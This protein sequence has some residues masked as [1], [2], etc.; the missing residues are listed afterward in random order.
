MDCGPSC[1]RMIAA[2]Y[3]KRFSI[4]FLQELTGVSR[5]GATMTDLRDAAEKI[6]FRSLPV[7]IPFDVLDKEQPFPAILHW[8]R[9]HFVVIYKIKGNKVYLADPAIGLISYTRE[10]FLKNW[11]DGKTEGMGLLLEP[12]P[13]FYE[14]DAYEKRKSITLSYFIKFLTPHRKLVIQL[15]LGLLAGSLLGLVTPFL[16]QMLVDIGVQQHDLQLVY[17]LLSAQL[18]FF[19]GNTMIFMIRSWILLHMNSRV[20]IAIISDFLI[21]LMRLPISFFDR[22]NLGDILQRVR[23]HDRIKQFLTS[24]SL[25]TVF[26]I[27]NMA[28]Y[29]VV[30]LAYDLVIF[31]IYLTGSMLYIAWILIF[32]KQRRIIDYKKFD[33]AAAAQSN[34]VQLVQGMQEIKLH[35]AETKKRLEWERIQVKLFKVN[36]SSLSLEQWQNVGGSFIN[37]LKNIFILF[38]AALQVMDGHM[39][40]GMM[41]AVSQITGQ[42]NSPLQQLITFIQQGQDA[43]ISLDRL[44]DIHNK[45]N[46]DEGLETSLA[47]DTSGDIVFENVSFR[48]GGASSPMVL[49]NISLVIP[50][51]KTTAIVGVSGSGKTTLMKLLLKFYEPAS[52]LIKVG[53]QDLAKVNADHWRRRCGVVMQEGLLFSDSVLGNVSISDQQPDLVRFTSALDVANIKEFVTELPLGAHTKV[54]A[55]GIGISAGQKQRIMI[56]RAIY[57][58][59]EYV[60][61]DEATSSLDSENE[62][63]ITEKVN[64]FGK[65]RTMLIIAHRLSTVKNADKIVVLHRGKVIEEGTHEELTQLKGKYYM[66]VKNQ[67]DLGA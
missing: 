44:S 4:Q 5:I 9:N 22:K 14:I 58:D 39:T 64:Q 29:G 30:L 60:F 1:L 46:E 35:H 65:S 33:Q 51:S 67:L 20:N 27:V 24:S 7:K 18:A 42:L 16:T 57:K 54:G 61:F 47:S 62:K 59:P 6:G 25:Q 10:E 13:R 32:L 43:K 66:L 56:A 53:N 55:E 63:E 28:V 19:V 23:D 12:S 38:V 50:S 52:G 17:I 2:S 34:E 41:L 31:G 26:S 36:M 3:G 37:E 48:Y 49:D 21:K 45:P 15:V 11:A 8:K 40:V